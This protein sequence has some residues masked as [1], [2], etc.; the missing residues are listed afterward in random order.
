MLGGSRVGA[1]LEAISEHVDTPSSPQ[2]Q[3]QSHTQR[4]PEDHEEAA[5]ELE[6]FNDDLTDDMLNL[7]L[8]RQ[9]NETAEDK[10]V[11]KVSQDQ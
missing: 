11:R 5:A 2:H 10:K 1:G 8:S 4:S 7:L 3:Q 9:K 6:E